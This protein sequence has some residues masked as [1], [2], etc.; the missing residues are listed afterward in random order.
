MVQALMESP[1]IDGLIVLGVVGGLQSIWKYI[2]DGSGGK[3]NTD[4]FAGGAVEH[5]EAYYREMM[6]LKQRYGKPMVV[7]FSLP[8]KAGMVNDTAA[9]LTRETGTTCYTSFTQAIRAYSALNKYAGYLRKI[10][11]RS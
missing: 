7:T 10:T 3:R 2:E 8:I 6:A 9:L 11:H 5:F 1:A 4:Y